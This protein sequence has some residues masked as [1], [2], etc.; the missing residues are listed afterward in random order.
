MLILLSSS[1]RKRYRDD[2]LRCVSAPIG[3]EI[4]FRYA[5]KLIAKSVWDNPKQFEETQGLVC[6]VDLDVV[7]GPCTLIPVRQVLIKKIFKHGSTLSVAMQVQNIALTN[8]IA[9][10]TSEIYA[11]SGSMSPV[12]IELTDKAE[13]SSGFFFFNVNDDV[14]SLSRVSTLTNWEKLTEVLLS[15]PGYKEEQFFWTVLG[16][17]ETSSYLITDTDNF[18]IWNPK[19]KLNTDYTVLVY[20]YHPDK[21]EW[22]PATSQLKILSSLDLSTNYSQDI[23]ID[24][25]YDLRRWSFKVNSKD[26]FPT[27]RAWIKIGPTGLLQKDGRSNLD[28]EWEID[29]PLEIQSLTIKD[30][31]I[32]VLLGLLLS[33]APILGFVAEDDLTMSTKWVFIIVSLVAGIFAAY[34]ARLGLKNIF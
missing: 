15:Q 33:I 4:Q 5:E 22:N 10:F 3:A 30:H 29:L 11:K 13:S 25:P 26:I 17:K 18:E 16:I 1:R 28:A 12:N 32:T 14:S 2:I 21:D 19:I 20:I 24:S 31:V 23:L 34:L 6:N 7:G 8:N 9:N 27:D